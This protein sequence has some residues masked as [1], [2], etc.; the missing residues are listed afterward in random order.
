MNKLNR[1]QCCYAIKQFLKIRSVNLVQIF[2]KYIL[3]M[4]QT[5]NKK[6]RRQN[7]DG[8]FINVRFQSNAYFIV[9]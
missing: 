9:V 8:S 2:M 5:A 3:R 7:F 1:L 4:N 6:K